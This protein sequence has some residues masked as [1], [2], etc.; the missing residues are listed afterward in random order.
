MSP[1]WAVI[2]TDKAKAER[3]QAAKDIADSVEAEEACRRMEVRLLVYGGPGKKPARAVS[4]SVLYSV[5]D[6]ALGE[7]DGLVQIL[8]IVHAS[9]EE[10]A[11]FVVAGA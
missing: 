1:R 2:E 4:Y 9:S 11:R 3:H 10:A 7:T 8:R 6:P 5:H